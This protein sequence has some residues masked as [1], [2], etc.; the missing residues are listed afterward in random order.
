LIALMVFNWMI[1]S[2][3]GKEC[4]N[5]RQAGARR[6]QSAA[7]PPPGLGRSGRVPGFLAGLPGPFPVFRILAGAANRAWTR[8]RRGLVKFIYRLDSE[9]ERGF[10]GN[11]RFSDIWIYN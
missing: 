2:R 10:W 8:R 7:G 1:Q 4:E 11:C 3:I 6:G 9:R 5:W